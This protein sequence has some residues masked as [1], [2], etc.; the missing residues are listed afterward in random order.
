MLR[1]ALGRIS[2]LPPAFPKRFFAGAD[3][4]F[5][6]RGINCRFVLPFF[7][8]PSLLIPSLALFSLLFPP[9]SSNLFLII[10]SLAFTSISLLFSDDPLRQSLPKKLGGPGERCDLSGV[11]SGARPTNGFW[12][13]LSQKS[14][15]HHRAV[16]TNPH[17]FRLSVRRFHPL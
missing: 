2:T 8:L 12:C 11:P 1:Q 5:Q 16:D 7:P 10:C 17:K 15:S 14:L 9:I 13:I 6:I 3:Q 4:G